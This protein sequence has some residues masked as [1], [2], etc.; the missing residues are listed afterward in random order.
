MRTL[1]HESSLAALPRVHLVQ[2]CLLRVKGCQLL[3]ATQLSLSLSLFLVER[4]GISLSLSCSLSCSLSPWQEQTSVG[5]LVEVNSW[6]PESRLREPPHQSE[7]SGG[8]LYLNHQMRQPWSERLK[9][10]QIIESLL[11]IQH[12]F[13]PGGHLLRRW[14]LDFSSSTWSLSRSSSPPSLAP[15]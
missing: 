5:L 6:S 13:K 2:S 7:Q 11:E 15:R 12:R 8:P 14:D 10:L 9:F 4:R 3:G 1:R